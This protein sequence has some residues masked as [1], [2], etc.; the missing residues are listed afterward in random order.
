MEGTW[1]HWGVTKKKVALDRVVE[2]GNSHKLPSSNA[3]E[4][5]RQDREDRGVSGRL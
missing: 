1:R 2:I 3:L 5:E 4:E